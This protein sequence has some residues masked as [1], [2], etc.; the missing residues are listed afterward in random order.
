MKNDSSYAFQGEG[1]IRGIS[2]GLK[3]GQLSALAGGLCCYCRPDQSLSV[4]CQRPSTG[5]SSPTP[6]T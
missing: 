3:G 1:L 5:T 4:T 2:Q 6:V